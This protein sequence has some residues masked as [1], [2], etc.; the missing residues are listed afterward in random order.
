M[1]KL[2]DPGFSALN[3]MDRE[4]L[5]LWRSFPNEI[6]EE[7]SFWRFKDI[8]SAILSK[9][10][11]ELEKVKSMQEF[12]DIKVLIFRSMSKQKGGVK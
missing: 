2:I 9:N 6:K 7:C 11:S 8:A 10:E 1:K 5:I 3:P 4:M 12:L